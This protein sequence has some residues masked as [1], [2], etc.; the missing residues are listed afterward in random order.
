[1]A[2]KTVARL[3]VE[4][5]LQ[6]GADVALARDQAHYLGNVLRLGDGDHVLLFNGRDGEWRAVLRPQSK[7]AVRAVCEQQLRPQVRPADIAYAFAPLKHARLDYLAQKA[8][9]LGVAQVEPVVTERTI[10]RKPNMERLKANLVEGAEQ[11]GVLWVPEARDPVALCAF[12]RD[13]P[14]ERSLIFC[15]EAAKAGSPIASLERVAPGPLTVLIGPEGGF[16]PVEQDRIRAHRNAIPVSL[17]PRIMRA[18]TAAVAA[19][20]LVQAVLGDWPQNR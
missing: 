11:C 14:D 1:M 4:V 12:L 5:S 2:G 8:S 9:E 3:F 20:S 15:D 7:K 10:A 19:L 13:L 6:P 17:G 18:D 16:T